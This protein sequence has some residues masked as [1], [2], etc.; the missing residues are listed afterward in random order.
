MRAKFVNEAIKHLPGRSKEEI[1]EMT[2][3]TVFEYPINKQY[4]YARSTPSFFT[5][6]E[7]KY[8]ENNW[9]GKS[10]L[11]ELNDL[12]NPFD[13]FVELDFEKDAESNGYEDYKTYQ[14]YSFSGP[15]Y[16]GPL[17]LE[18]LINN[19]GDRSYQFWYDASPIITGDATILSPDP[20]SFPII[21][22]I[23]ERV[24]DEIN[25]ENAEEDEDDD[26]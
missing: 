5:D 22:E 8:I 15:E 19:L 16:V 17:S 18:V 11:D 2:R 10:T 3:K 7:L 4:L 6:K 14:Q 26:F 25:N 12:F 9:D 1:R 24:I 23:I 20:Q 21:P 13:I